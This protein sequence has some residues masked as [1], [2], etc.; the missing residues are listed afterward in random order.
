MIYTA[1][2]IEQSI[3]EFKVRMETELDFCR[4]LFE[5]A[6]IRLMAA[7]YAYYICSEEF[8]TDTAYDIA[9]KGWYCMGRALGVLAEDETSPCLDFDPKHPYAEKGIELA[10]RFIKKRR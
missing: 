1:A 3:A 9:E 7:K 5:D 2:Y 10:N 4:Q 8:I 6:T